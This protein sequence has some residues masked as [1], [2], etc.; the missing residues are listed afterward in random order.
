MGELTRK[1][2]VPVSDQ[3]LNYPQQAMGGCGS[4]AF[5]TALPRGAW[6]AYRLLS[7]QWTGGWGRLS[8]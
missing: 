1:F 2:Q 7:G 6:R 5:L 3:A 4:G 8:A